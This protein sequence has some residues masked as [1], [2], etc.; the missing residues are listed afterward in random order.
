[1][2]ARVWPALERF[3]RPVVFHLSGQHA[4]DVSFQIH[5]HQ[6]I[7]LNVVDL[8]DGDTLRIQAQALG[9]LRF[10]GFRLLMPLLA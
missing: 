5:F 1:M 9:E 8:E 10:G 6:R 4:H 2:C 3:L 7:G